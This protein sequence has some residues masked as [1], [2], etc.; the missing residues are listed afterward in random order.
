[1]LNRFYKSTPSI[2]TANCMLGAPTYHSVN[3]QS[4][5]AAFMPG[6][7]AL[8]ATSEVTGL[9][10]ILLSWTNLSGA[11]HGCHAEGSGLLL[12]CLRSRE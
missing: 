2:A 8:R 6:M 10:S 12:L 9:Y 3:S 4:G 7:R 11:P 5:A 1:M